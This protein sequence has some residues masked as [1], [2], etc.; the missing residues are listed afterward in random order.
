MNSIFWRFQVTPIF[1]TSRANR[2]PMEAEANLPNNLFSGLIGGLMHCRIKHGRRLMFGM[3]KKAR[4]LSRLLVVMLLLEPNGIAMS[5][6]KSFWQRR[7]LLMIKAK[8]SMTIIFLM[9]LSTLLWKNWRE[10]SEL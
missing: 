4:L 3:V 7:A 6:R 8:L 9:R 2:L 10:L 5:L 1:V